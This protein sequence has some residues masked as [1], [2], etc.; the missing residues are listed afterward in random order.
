MAAR[1]CELDSAVPSPTARLLEDYKNVNDTAVTDIP[2]CDD[3]ENSD[4]TGK[5]EK[6]FHVNVDAFDDESSPSCS[7]NQT[8]TPTLPLNL[9][10][11]LGALVQ[12]ALMNLKESNAIKS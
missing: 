11:N 1:I 12:K 10:E 5:E 7:E 6:N 2:D 9:P 8:P 3:K 4:N